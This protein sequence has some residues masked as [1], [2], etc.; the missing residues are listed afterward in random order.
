MQRR[1]AGS[2]R[3]PDPWNGDGRLCDV[4][5][6]DGFAGAGGC[7]L[8]HL[9]R[10]AAGAHARL[11]CAR[12]C[13]MQIH[14]CAC[15]PPKVQARTPAAPV[16]GVLAQPC[17]LTSRCGSGGSAAWIAESHTPIA[18]R[19]HLDQ[20][21]SGESPAHLHLLLRRQRR[22]DGQH[23]QQLVARARGGGGSAAQAGQGSGPVLC[24]DGVQ[25][26]VGQEGG[27]GRGAAR[28][29]SLVLGEGERVGW[30][31]ARIKKNTSCPSMSRQRVGCG[32]HVA[33]E[34]FRANKEQ[35]RV[36][37]ATQ[38]R[39]ATSAQRRS[40]STAPPPPPPLRQQLQLPSRKEKGRGGM[41]D[42][43][44]AQPPHLDQPLG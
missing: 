42:G 9:H 7:R 25:G 26:Q 21:P 16:L 36:L 3:P 32:R 35:L 24:A 1:Q 8:K 2:L 41:G 15:V 27:E 10:A 18:C 14:A 38:T 22:V 28:F 31:W 20:N 19:C 33:V 34:S 37:W 29:L 23:Q 43:G 40:Y 17:T 12:G 13:R 6:Q 44:T 4:G 30:A 39:S 5:R 11:A